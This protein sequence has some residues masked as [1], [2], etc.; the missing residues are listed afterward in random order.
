MPQ[1]PLTEKS[2]LP[3]AELGQVGWGFWVRWAA[4][5]VLGL[6]AT[7]YAFMYAS[8]IWDRVVVLKPRMDELVGF[9]LLLA[10]LGAG[11]G[12]MQ[13]LV[14]RRQLSQAWWWILATMGGRGSRRRWL[15]CGLGLR[16]R[17]GR[18]PV[19]RNQAR[20]SGISKAAVSHARRDH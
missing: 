7:S 18:R 5:T 15:G 1:R 9:S 3:T 6:S 17:P 16:R 11:V 4:A 20:A 10:V 14:L 13:W 19:Q 2:P 12:V 8:D